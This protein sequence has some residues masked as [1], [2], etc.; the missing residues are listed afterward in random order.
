MLLSDLQELVHKQSRSFKATT[1]KIAFL[2]ELLLAQVRALVV[3]GTVFLGMAWAYQRPGAVPS[4]QGL[5]GRLA[6][7]LEAVPALTNVEWI[8]ATCSAIWLIRLSTNV[9]DRFRRPEP[10]STGRSP[11][12]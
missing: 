10:A 4:L 5:H 8:F 12:V 1:T 11:V 2:G 3:A 6:R 9:L 7:R